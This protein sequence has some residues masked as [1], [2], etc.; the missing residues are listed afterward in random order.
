MATRGKKTTIFGGPG[1][2]SSNEGSTLEYSENQGVDAMDRKCQDMFFTFLFAV[3]WI[4]MIIVAAYGFDKGQPNKLIYGVDY[5]GNLCGTDNSGV[6]HGGRDFTN[7]KNL[8]YPDLTKRS[9]KLCVESCPDET[10]I[11][12]PTKPEEVICLNGIEPASTTVELLQQYYNDQCFMKYQSSD[13]LNRCIPFANLVTSN[14]SATQNYTQEEADAAARDAKSEDTSQKIFSDLN[15]AKW[16]IFGLCFMAVLLGFVWMFLLRWFAAFMV[17]FTVFLIIAG[18]VWITIQFND[19]ANEAKDKYNS[20][21]ESQRVSSDRNNY[22]AL[23]VLFYV[24]LG[25]TILFFLVIVAM[26]RRIQL[27]IEII[28]EAS[29]AMV[30]MPLI[31]FFPIVIFLILLAFFVYWLTVALFLATAGEIVYDVNGDYVEYRSDSTLRNMQIYHFFGLLW[32]TAFWLGV[33]EC[34]VAGAIASWYFARDKDK[35]L[36]DSPVYSAFKRTLRYHFGSIAFG[37]LI[38]AIVQFIRAVINWVEESLDGKDNDLVKCLLRCFQCYF[39]CVE[40]FLKF[41]NRNAYIQIAIYGYPFC[42]AAR[43]AFQLIFRNILRVATVNTIGEFLIF[44][45]KI[46]ICAICGA[47]ALR[48]FKN[49]DNPELNYYAIPVMLVIILSYMIASAFMSIYDMAVDTILLCFCE[50]VERNDG[51]PGREYFMSEDLQEYI[52]K[53]EQKQAEKKHTNKK[54]QAAVERRNN[55]QPQTQAATSAESTNPAVASADD[56]SASANPYA[57]L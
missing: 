52:N 45:G 23:N 41:I 49:L 34:T 42:E 32:N 8:Y 12:P 3:F 33:S 29:K 2:D 47:T 39:K 50:D 53:N 9:M 5:E 30:A 18:M 37:S 15:R 44:L 10:F 22:R 24:S 19:N 27:A 51:S 54:M 40:R 56:A 17:W 20:I 48:I 43:R 6:I 25:L 31:I 14:N 38:I 1:G 16:I 28:E 57:K 11:F 21:P 36:P 26:R 13:I 46:F 35:D 55:G 7:K 4:G